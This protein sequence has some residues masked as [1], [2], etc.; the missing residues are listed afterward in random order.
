MTDRRTTPNPAWVDSSAPAQV[1]VT[2]TDLLDAPNGT[3]DRQLIYGDPITVLGAREGHSYVRSD[4]DG[5]IGF[6]PTSALINPTQP[7]HR[8]IARASHAYAQ[9]DMKSPDRLPLT[10]G[11]RLTALS[12]TPRF[13]ETA[14][15]FVPKQHIAPED[16]HHNDP[17]TIAEIF[18]G[19]PYLWGGNS[20]TG[21]DCSGLIQ[22]ACLACNIACDGDSDQQ[23]RNLGTALPD[24]TPP[25]RN[26][27]L[28]WKGHVALVYDSETLIHANA[29]H[30]AT[31]FEPISNALNR[32]AQSDGLLTAHRRL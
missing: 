10:F 7:T 30:M 1:G 16:Q 27:L 8:I 6:V 15:G 12:E 9:A 17:A 11:S 5:Y 18:L 4:K 21:I 14:A 23:A 32:I 25:R 19:T 31:S 29:H 22:A 2:L 3:R 13:I 26:D 28:F 20:G 24:D